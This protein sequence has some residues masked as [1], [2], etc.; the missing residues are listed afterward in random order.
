MISFMEQF[1]V[2]EYALD[3]DFKIW[4]KF[5]SAQKNLGLDKFFLLLII[6]TVFLWFL[7]WPT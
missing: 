1:T 3:Y 2:K 7:V 6:L 5:L 4:H